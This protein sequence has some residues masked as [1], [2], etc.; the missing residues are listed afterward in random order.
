MGAGH[1]HHD[2][3]GGPPDAEWRKMSDRVRNWGRWGADD[4]L[5]TLNHITPEAL[6]Y[7]GKMIRKGK[8]ISCGVPF[9]AQ[10]PQGAHG[11][12]RNPI[13]LM[14]IDGG[15]DN[16]DHWP[17]EW[18]G[19]TEKWVKDIYKQGPGRS[20]DDYV[21]MPLQSCTQWDALSPFY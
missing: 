16:F 18:G 12:R 7:A 13:H 19:P 8:A 6:A 17:D 2:E 9:N 1:N 3:V 10:G 11:L 15:E 21:I 14:T 5:G 4:Q 20:T